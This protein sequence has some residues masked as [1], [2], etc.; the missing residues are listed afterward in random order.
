MATLTQVRPARIVGCIVKRPGAGLKQLLEGGK[1]LDDVKLEFGDGITLG[2]EDGAVDV[3]LRRLL[4]LQPGR[5]KT[6][7]GRHGSAQ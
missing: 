6:S 3:R 7:G 4:Q 2:F 1:S 5:G